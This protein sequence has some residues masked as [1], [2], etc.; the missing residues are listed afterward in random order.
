M[1]RLILLVH[2]QLTWG[3]RYNILTQHKHNIQLRMWSIK[4]N[5]KSLPS[6]CN[7]RIGAVVKRVLS[8]GNFL[9]IFNPFKCY[10]L[11]SQYSQ[12]SSN[13]GKILDKSTITT[14]DSHETPKFHHSIRTN[15]VLNRLDLLSINMA[16]K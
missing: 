5:K 14:S 16:K 2:H 12:V 4:V 13:G 6:T 15:L 9:Q 3:I 8:F 10:F 11:L 1:H 7:A